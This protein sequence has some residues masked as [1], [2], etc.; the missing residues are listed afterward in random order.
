MP[1]PQTPA[2]IYGQTAAVDGQRYTYSAAIQGLAP[3]ASATDIFTLTGSASMT[4]RLLRVRV[5]GIKTTAG[6]AVD[7]QLLK[8]STADTGGTSTAPT[9]IPY[10]KNSPAATAVVAAYTANP[11][12]GTSVGL[13]AVDNIFIP[14]ATAAGGLIDWNFGNRPGQAIVLRG[15]A[16]QACLN[17][18]GVTIGGGA[19]D[20]WV[21]WTEDATS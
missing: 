15:A 1:T 5:S 12:A 16:D 13:L 3:A 11:T 8:R 20:V 19:L 17:L 4:V 21:E 10:D 2:P 9:I 14:L 7:F 18:N 6:A